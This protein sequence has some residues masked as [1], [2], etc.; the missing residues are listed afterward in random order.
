MNNFNWMFNPPNLFG[1]SRNCNRNYNQNTAQPSDNCVTGENRVE[2]EPSQHIDTAESGEL[3]YQSDYPAK[4][5]EPGPQGPRGEAGPPG[6]PG[7]RGETGPQGVT[8]PQGPQG[9]TGPERGNWRTRS[10]RAFRLPPKQHVCVI[11]RN[12]AYLIRKRQTSA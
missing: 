2:S 1:M 5:G 6:C 8:G 3:F 9:A 11:L 4:C 12:W 10:G 7:E